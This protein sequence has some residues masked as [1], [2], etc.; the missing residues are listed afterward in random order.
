MVREEERLE[1]TPLKSLSLCKEVN[2]YHMSRLHETEPS[3][4]VSQAQDMMT[5]SW[6]LKQ[7]REYVHQDNRFH[8]SMPC[9]S[10]F[11]RISY[12]S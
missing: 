9:P 8:S 2:T 11:D 4:S 12:P 5:R 1:A 7:G 6:S 10:H 3:K